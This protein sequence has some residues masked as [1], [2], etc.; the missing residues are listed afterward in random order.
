MTRED[1]EEDEEYR[2]RWPQRPGQTPPE[3]EIRQARVR[4]SQGDGQV[5]PPSPGNDSKWTSHPT[6]YDLSDGA[7]DGT[8]ETRVL[9]VVEPSR[10]DNGRQ[11][12]APATHNRAMPAQPRQPVQPQR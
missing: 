7:D 10:F 4:G 6:S 12:Q 5:V 2:P 11:S 8:K 1:H 9:P 3:G